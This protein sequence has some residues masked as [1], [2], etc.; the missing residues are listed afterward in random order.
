MTAKGNPLALYA[1]DETGCWLWQG[2][3]TPKGYGSYGKLGAHR[4][5]FEMLRGPV[6]A[7]LELDHLCRVRHCVNPDHLEPVTQRANA[8]R[9]VGACAENAQVTHCPSGHAYEGQNL[10]VGTNGF[11]RCRPCTARYQREYQA[12][13]RARELAV[14]D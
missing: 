2:R 5:V 7:G 3:I 4:L 9:G 6:P 8:L 12:R 10:R 13:K 1:I 11:R 14:I